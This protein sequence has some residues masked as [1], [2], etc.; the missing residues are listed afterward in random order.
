MSGLSVHSISSSLAA[1]HQ[2][3]R[4]QTS[5]AKTL[6]QLSTG[7]RINSAQDDP[8]GLIAQE[9]FRSEMT[10]S[11]SALKNTQ[12]ANSMLN[13]AESGMRQISNLLIEAKGLA[14]EAANTGAMTPQ[15]IEA[16]QIQ[17]NAILDSIDRFSSMTNWLGK[18]LLNGTLSSENGGAL[19][20]L[21][22]EVVSSQQVTVPIEGTQTSRVGNGSDFLMELRSGGAASLSTN[23]MLADSILSAA[24]SQIAMQRG[25]IGSVQK[26]TLD[27]N[28]NALQDSLV[29]LTSAK[30]IISDTDY[31]LAVSNSVRDR[32]LLQSGIQSLGLINQ[33]RLYAASL[34]NS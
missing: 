32:I 33:N 26:Y 1:T 2:V 25:E 18:P 31:A 9:L 20:Q 7:S 29:Q 5:L 24:I 34:L 6:T 3:Q 28:I 4:T 21:G 23:P 14:V 12:L 8:A 19:F 17:M 16:N 15:M 10:A 27:S 11:Q 30:S 13:V 22:P